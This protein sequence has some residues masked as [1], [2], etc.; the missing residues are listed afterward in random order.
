MGDYPFYIVALTNPMTAAGDLIDG[1]AAGVPQRLAIGAAGQSLG[2]TAG[3]PA[4]L[5]ALQPQATTGT[6]GYTLINGTGNIITWAVPNDGALH[7]FLIFINL[8]VTS[9]QTGGAAGLSGLVSPSGASHS[10]GLLAGGAGAGLTQIDNA[11][12]AQ[13]GSTVTLAQTS[14]LTA[15]A[16]VVWAEIWGS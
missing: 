2:I 9:A 4:W 7:R 1:A 3:A 16:A 11:Y 13:A 12:F 14:A 10:P 5:Q 15:G 8:L 6:G